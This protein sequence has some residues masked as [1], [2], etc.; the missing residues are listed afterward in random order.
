MNYTQFPI[1]IE[2]KIVF[3]FSNIHVFFQL[4]SRQSPKLDGTMNL[5]SI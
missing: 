3:F 1:E 2:I 4:K 5:R